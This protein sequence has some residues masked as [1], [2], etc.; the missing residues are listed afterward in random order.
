MASSGSG[1]GASIEREYLSSGFGNPGIQCAFSRLRLKPSKTCIYCAAQRYF[2]K[3]VGLGLLNVGGTLKAIRGEDI[4]STETRLP[5]RST[6]IEEEDTPS[7]CHD[8]GTDPFLISVAMAPKALGFSP[9]NRPKRISP[10]RDLS[11]Q[12]M[13]SQVA[14]EERCSKFPDEEGRSSRSSEEMSPPWWRKRNAD[15]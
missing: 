10:T 4:N 7:G 6:S 5:G 8:D 2:E 15:V 9:G 1:R 14:A 13:S 11:N 12:G 3:P